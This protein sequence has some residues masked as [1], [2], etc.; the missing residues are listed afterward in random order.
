M[1]VDARQ[2]RLANVDAF[3]LV[4]RTTPEQLTY[5]GLPVSL[6]RFQALREAHFPPPRPF[7]PSPTIKPE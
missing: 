2:S 3:V 7:E 6:G 5:V 1:P 4:I